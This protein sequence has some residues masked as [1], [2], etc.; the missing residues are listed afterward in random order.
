MLGQQHRGSGTKLSKLRRG[1]NDRRRGNAG[2]GN[3][4]PP[5][6]ELLGSCSEQEQFTNSI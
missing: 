3:V 5:Q 6:E 4:T 1:L 2:G